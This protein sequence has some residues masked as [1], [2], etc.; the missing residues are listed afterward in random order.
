MAVF[1]APFARPDHA[2][3]A[4]RAA[5][6]MHVRQAR[7][8]ETWA[9]DGLAPFGLGIGVCS[10]QV[11]AALLGSEERLEYTLVGDTVNL[12]QRL[13]DL[14]RPAGTTVISDATAAAL[15]ARDEFDVWEM[16]ARTVKGRTTPVR[17]FQLWLRT[18]AG[19]AGPAPME[20]RGTVQGTPQAR[21]TGAAQTAALA[22]Q[23]APLTAQPALMAAQPALHA[24]QTAPLAGQ[25]APLAGQTAPLAGQTAP[26][27]G[28]GME[29]FPAMG[30]PAETGRA[31]FVSQ[32]YPA[33]G[34]RW[35]RTR[36]RAGAE[37][38]S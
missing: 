13:G 6:V 28:D 16:P 24:A 18:A 12:A 26:L 33:R 8:D 31:P 19:A 21:P 22:V 35:W 32:K 3:A 25:T 29:R 4:C 2:L 20:S 38:A 10:G 14:A 34:R 36:G 27:A 37:D 17:P 23:P 1:G 7:L 15:G 30:E 11:A 9:A 5:G